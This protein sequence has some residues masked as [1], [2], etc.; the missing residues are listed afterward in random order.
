MLNYKLN[1]LRPD[2]F[3]RVVAAL[4]PITDMKIDSRRVG[5]L[6]ARKHEAASGP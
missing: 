5:L 6:G 4:L 2:A 1:Y 3:S